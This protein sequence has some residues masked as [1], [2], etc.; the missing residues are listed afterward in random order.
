MEKGVAIDSLHSQLVTLSRDG[1]YA[2]DRFRDDWGRLNTNKYNTMKAD[3]SREVRN[4]AM[5]AP[6]KFYNGNYYLYD[7]KVYEAVDVSVIEQ[8]YQLLL[9]DLYIAPMIYNTSVRRDVFLSTIR[10]YNILRPTFSIVA[11]RN[12][13]VDFGSGKKGP[14]ILPFSPEYHVTYYHPYDYDPKAKCPRFMNF[15]K[16]VLPDRTSRMILQMFL[17]LGLIERGMAYNLYGGNASSKVEMCMLLVGGGANGKSVL[18]DIACALFGND[19]IS[20]MDYAELTADGDE[21]MRGR[22]PIRNAIFN[23]SSDSDPR[24]F[25]R[26][27]TGMFKRMVSGEPV[28]I[29]SLGKNISEPQTVPYL[30][31]ALNDLPLSDDASLG[32][33]RRLQYVSFDVT[34]PKERQDPELAARIIDKELSGVF[35]WVFR[36]SLEIRKR[37]FQFPAAEGSI[38]QMLRSLIGSQPIRAWIKA[39]GIGCEAETKGEICT[40]Y[41]SNDLYQKF[42]KFCADNGLEGK[43]I[44]TVQKFG[45]DMW[46][47]YGFD[48]K[49]TPGGMMYKLYRVL[50]ADLD[51]DILIDKIKLP[52]E[53]DEPDDEFIRDDD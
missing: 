31:F 27:N 47:I 43:E 32:F 29:R 20:K 24:K 25:G 18:F 40:W 22:W 13:V 8:A 4:L 36:G 37:K 14:E 44:P 50:E 21:G 28:P 49:K 42:V 53:C 12:G 38:M 30:V 46:N 7:G 45:R 35:N 26:K 1:S 17:G 34:I 6:V 19:K 48:R 11:F 51:E 16:E 52:G 3:F 33:I 2:F 9:T 41:K 15:I 23:W 39:Y 10:F 5:R